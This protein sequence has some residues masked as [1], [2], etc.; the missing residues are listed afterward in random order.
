MAKLSPVAKVA[1]DDQLQ[2]LN[3]I[4]GLILRAKNLNL[5]DSVLL[6][7][8]VHLD[9]QTKIHGID[10]QELQAFLNT[11]CPSAHNH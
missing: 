7:N 5:H 11:V 1:E 3:E 6:L 8:M 4:A 10:D 2:L 9:L